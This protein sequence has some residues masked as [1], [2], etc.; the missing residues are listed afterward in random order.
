MLAVLGTV[1]AGC[2]LPTDSKPRVIQ[3]DQLLPDPT[4]SPST[5]AVRPGNKGIVIYLIKNGST[6]HVDRFASSISANSLLSA[7]LAPVPQE[8]T[9]RGLSTFI[10]PKTRV[11]STSRD[12]GLIVVDLSKEMTNVA[13]PNDKLAYKQIA[14]TLISGK[15]A[16]DQVAIEIEGK[17]IKIPTE[18]GPKDQ[19][20]MGDFMTST[21][22]TSPQPDAAP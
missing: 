4:A 22:S 10:P 15:L 5:T 9:N 20:S 6:V 11:L 8:E 14:F 16:I 12:K 3:P 2:S 18:D 13:S 7:L 19:V 17:P 1:G 21:T